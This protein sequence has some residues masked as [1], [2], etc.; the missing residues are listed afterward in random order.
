MDFQIRFSQA[1][2]CFIL[3]EYDFNCNLLSQSY[4]EFN[5]CLGCLNELILLN[6]CR[7]DVYILGEIS[8]FLNKS[9]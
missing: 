2:Y 8:G 5:L 7:V 3:S 9:C 1:K 4:D 6:N